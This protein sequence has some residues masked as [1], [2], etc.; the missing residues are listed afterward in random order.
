[1]D[2]FLP[3]TQPS[4]AALMR[5]GIHLVLQPWAFLYSLSHRIWLFVVLRKRSPHLCFIFSHTVVSLI[6]KEPC[7]SVQV[8][9]LFPFLWLWKIAEVC[10]L[11]GE[12]S[13]VAFSGEMSVNNMD[14][15]GYHRSDT[16]DF[17]PISVKQ[18]I[19]KYSDF[20]LLTPEQHNELPFW[21]YSSRKAPW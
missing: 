7:G 13:L 6:T 15:T 19:A 14:S 4:N 2:H 20:K 5:G 16:D 8:A 17:W 12:M 18:H 11:T 9:L 1:M 10:S 21:I 3:F